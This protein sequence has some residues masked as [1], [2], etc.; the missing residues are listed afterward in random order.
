MAA[1]YIASTLRLWVAAIFGVCAALAQAAGGYTIDQS[2]ET[3][4]TP[5]M[6]MAQVRQA[7]GRP[8]QFIKY[9]NQP[10][11]TFTYRVIGKQDALFDVDFD[12]NDQVVST[13]ERIIS[14]DGDSS[15]D[16]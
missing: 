7:L 15:R 5:G 12:A 1:K 13:N 10:G 8:S 3:L 6:N 9:R 14:L 11:P 4:V 16:R 2:E